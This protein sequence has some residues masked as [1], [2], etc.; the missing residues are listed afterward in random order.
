MTP[1]TRALR[2]LGFHHTYFQILESS[3]LIYELPNKT[4]LYDMV[5]VAATKP[6]VE[7]ISRKLA[8]IHF[9]QS[10]KGLFFQNKQGSEWA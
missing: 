4:S 5:S 3:L 2:E 10:K 1:N 8:L 7:E 9:F 6:K